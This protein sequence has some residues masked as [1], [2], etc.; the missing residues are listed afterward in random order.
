M[1]HDEIIAILEAHRDGKPL[2][3]KG[4]VGWLNYRPINLGN[5]LFNL[6]KVDSTLTLRPK[7]K[8]RRVY[9]PCSISGAVDF[10][11]TSAEKAR[12]DYPDSEIVA[13]VEEASE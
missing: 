10:G 2:Q 7:P 6:G 3:Q 12:D 8:P 4:S 11:Y 13:F 9:V 1:T 5:L